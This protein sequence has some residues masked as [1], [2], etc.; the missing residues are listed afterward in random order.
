MNVTLKR[1]AKDILKL[2]GTAGYS[3]S[4][5]CAWYDGEKLKPHDDEDVYPLDWERV[6]ELVFNPDGIKYVKPE[7]L[8][9][10]RSCFIDHEDIIDPD[11]ETDDILIQLAAFGQIVYG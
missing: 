10:L 5:W 7:T 2:S 1:T 4:Y 9:R 6:P 3:I 11:G 8:A